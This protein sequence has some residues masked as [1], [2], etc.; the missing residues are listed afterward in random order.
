M[1]DLVTN[2]W[3]KLEQEDRPI[4]REKERSPDRP[5]GI[6]VSSQSE[7]AQNFSI[8]LLN[9]TSRIANRTSD[10]SPANPDQTRPSS[11]PTVGLSRLSAG[12]QGGRG[13]SRGG[14]PFN[15][16]F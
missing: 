15:S 13:R 7:L 10:F 4:Y 14:R 16:H 12:V 3:D 2:F 11:T 5:F 8:G 6:K 9:R 1:L